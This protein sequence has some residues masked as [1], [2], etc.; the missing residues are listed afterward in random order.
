MGNYYRFVNYS[1]REFVD[2]DD[3]RVGGTKNARACGGALAF[4]M[5]PAGPDNL[6]RCSFDFEWSDFAG[7]RDI[8]AALIEEMRSVVPSS[9]GAT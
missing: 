4:L 6:I 1:K 9:Q 5:E 8:T 2:L 3:T 7:Y